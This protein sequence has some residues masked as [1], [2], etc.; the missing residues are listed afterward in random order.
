M[1][2]AAGQS[3]G[4]AGGSSACTTDGTCD[5]ANESC[6]CPDCAGAPACGAGCTAV[7][8]TNVKGFGFTLE[9][10]A[11]AF[12]GP[13]PDNFQAILL[14]AGIPNGKFPLTKVQK[15]SEC[16]ATAICPM[17][18]SE[19]YMGKR[20]RAVSGS[21]E[22]SGLEGSKFVQV[23]FEN[24]MQTGDDVTYLSSD[25]LYLELLKL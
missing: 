24:T 21:F 11:S 5:P 2:G 16:G 14:Q 20:Y 3:G 18:V 25:C 22:K 6:T 12:D 19:K 17:M 8:V 4:G 9:G 13:M 15:A 1:G 7:T 23:R 10:D